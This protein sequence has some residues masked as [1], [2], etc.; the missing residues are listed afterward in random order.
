MG[1]LEL[2]R[3][4]EFSHEVRRGS[5]GASHVVPGYSLV[6]QVEALD[7]PPG[8]SRPA[9][10]ETPAPGQCRQRAPSSGDGQSVSGAALPSSLLFTSEFLLI[11]LFL[12]EA[13][14]GR[15]ESHT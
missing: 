6:S 14:S 9:R 12:C 4:Y 11:C 8:F 5:Q 3:K 2:E 1:F 10:A 15:K 13:L 7:S